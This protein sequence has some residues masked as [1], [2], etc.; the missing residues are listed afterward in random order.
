MSF[1]QKIIKIL[2]VSQT[3]SR[4][5]RTQSSDAFR[6]SRT[7]TSQRGA[8]GGMIAKQLHAD[9]TVGACM[10]CSTITERNLPDR[11]LRGRGSVSQYVHEGRNRGMTA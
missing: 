7:P 6:S 9:I 5:L 4:L 8:R 1:V 10:I 3:I 2:S 11:R